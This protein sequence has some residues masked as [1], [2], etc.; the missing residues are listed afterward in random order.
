[1]SAVLKIAPASASA[2]VAYL[3]HKLAYYTD[4]W[5]LAED[6]AQGIT[7]IVVIDARSDEVY[8]AGHIC[9]ALSFPHR[10][11]NAESTAHLDCSKVYITYCDG[12][13]CNGSTKAALKL[14]SLGFQVKELIGGLDFW[15]RDGHPMAWG[16]AA[17][18]WP[19]GTPAAHCGC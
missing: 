6:L 12:I 17:G 19:L 9:G 16:A 5:D 14:A 8:Q 1:M 7:A 10:T 18:E 13:G 15:K 4:A 3:Q 11:M 2:S